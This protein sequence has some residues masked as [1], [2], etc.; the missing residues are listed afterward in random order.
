LDCKY[1]ISLVY[2]KSDIKNELMKVNKFKK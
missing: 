1:T 2:N